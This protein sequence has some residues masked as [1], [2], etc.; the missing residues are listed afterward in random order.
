MDAENFMFMNISILYRCGQKYYDKRLN[1]YQIGFGQILFLILIYE[2]EGINLQELAQYG[3]Y[4]KGTI[5]KSVQKLEEQSFIHSTPD[6][7]DRRM[8]RLYTS[9]KTKDIISQIYMIRREWWERLCQGMN[10]EE[11]HQ[12]ETSMEKLCRNARL[13]EEA[14]K[15]EIRLFGLQKL[16]LLDY[17]GTVASTVF[18]GGCNFRCPFCHNADLVFLPEN[19]AEIKEADIVNFFQKRQGILE[20]VCIS[21]GE[22]LLNDELEP[23]LHY[24]KAMGYKV[25]VDTNGSHP[26]KLKHLIEEG[27]IDYI[28]MDIKNSPRRYAETIDVQAFDMSPIIETVSYLLTNPIPY[29]FR[30]TV[31]KEFHTLAD[32]REIAT[33]I[34]GA[35]AYYLQNFEDGEHVIRK[36]LHPVSKAELQAFADVMKPFVENTSIRGME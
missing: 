18:T 32:I 10:V 12:L 3:C 11:I 14:D 33:W 17:P 16:S 30:T 19:T 21:G 20:G 31:V 29:E 35:N 5:T 27:L 13:Y 6:E 34:Q 15:K 22:P 36:G 25:K 4:D 23:F 28:A 9:D 26:L 2:N 8:R 7:K 1:E 24:L